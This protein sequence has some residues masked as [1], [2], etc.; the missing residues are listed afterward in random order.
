MGVRQEHTSGEIRRLKRC[1]NDMVSVLALPAMW[2]GSQP[3]QIV[4]TLLDALLGMLCL[5]F[6]YARF[7]D[8]AGGAPIELLKIAPSTTWMLPDDIHKTVNQWFGDDPQKW[9]SR[10]RAPI[11]DEDISIVSQRCGL[12]GEIGVIVAGSGRADFPGQTETLLLSVAANQAVIGLHEARLLMEQTRVASELDRRVAQRTAEL[13]AA[14]EALREEVAERRRAE[15]ALAASE[16]NLRLVFDRIPGL[17]ALL[18]SAGDVEL[19]NPQLVEYCGRSLDELR[20]WGTSDTVHAE[21]LPRVAQIF[22]RSIKSGNP[23]DF[24]ARLRRFDGIYRWFQVR[25]LPVRDENGPILRWCALHTDIDDRKRAEDALRVSECDLSSIINTIP[26]L[27]WSARPDGFCDFLNQRWLDFTGLSA[28]Q[29]RGSG[30]GAAIHP[31]DAKGMLGSWQ[32]ALVTGQLADVEVRM[33]RFDGEYRWFLLRA[34]PLRDESGKIVKWYGTNTDI[35]DRKRAEEE[36]QRSEAFLAEGERLS[37]SGS[38]VWRLDTDEITFSEQL[39]R[40]FEFDHDTPVTFERIGGRVH[41][42][43]IPLLTDK[44]EAARTG[45]RALN[46]EIRLRM[47]NGSVKYLR[48]IAHGTRDRDGRPEIIGAIQDITERRLSEDAL[49]QAR[50]DL[51]HVTRVTSLGVLT[52]SI[53]HEV[54]QPLSGIITNAGTCL[55]M[56]AAEPPNVE[57]ARETAKRTIRDGNR[58][59]EL[60]TRLRALFSKKEFTPEP[61]DLNQATQEVIALSLCELQRNRVILRREFADNLP[62]VNGDRVQLQQVILNLLKNASDAMSSVNDRPRQLQIRTE[63]GT[64]DQVR[65]TVQ[66]MGVG[67]NP[68]AMDRLFQAFYTTKNDGMGIGLY[69]SHSIIERHNG[70]L[71]AEP[72]DGPGATFSFS[73]PPRHGGASDAA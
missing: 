2:S 41:S 10:L 47:P 18:T 70:R 50:S 54:N 26:M 45:N 65:L 53:A 66:D 69:V 20:L 32:L 61:V 13:A 64:D 16:H 9:P 68:Q 58:A 30:W 62:V 72:N 36:L 7:E 21:D 33:R 8:P 49:S 15:E 42:D 48:T 28:E 3:S 23:Y 43:D 31:D 67:L 19:V 55:R 17:V 56:L 24:E 51:A 60:I 27:A 63:R 34:S 6:V 38:F 35:D 40:T 37:L 59:S 71:W 29:A 25:G 22:A 44:I 57:G 11:S 5:D 4:H 14:N 52:A 12:H 73:I 46:Y 1:L 39:Y